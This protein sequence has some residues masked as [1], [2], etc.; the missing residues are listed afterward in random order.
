MSNDYT[1][2][3]GTDGNG[4]RCNVENIDGNVVASGW[5]ETPATAIADAQHWASVTYN[6][7]QDRLSELKRILENER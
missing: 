6:Q 5:G 3:V 2:S 7:I 1:G 4:W